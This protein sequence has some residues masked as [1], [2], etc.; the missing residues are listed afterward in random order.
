METAKFGSSATNRNIQKNTARDSDM[1]AFGNTVA[2]KQEVV[3]NPES[4]AFFLQ[5][6]NRIDYLIAYNK[7]GL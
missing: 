2:Y 5:C 4:K 7:M 3:I 6:S 1:G